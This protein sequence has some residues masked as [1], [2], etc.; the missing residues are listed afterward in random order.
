MGG[1]GRVHGCI[2]DINYYNHLFLNPFDGKLTPYYATS[3][4][5]KYVYPS[6]E[7]L[8]VE[9]CPSLESG[10]RKMVKSRDCNLPAVD[11]GMKEPAYYPETDIYGISRQM[12]KIQHLTGRNVIRQWNDAFLDLDDPEVPRMVVKALIGNG[13]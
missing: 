12:Y 6:V 4:R 9:K 3:M 10:F 13:K 2:V 5:D 1:D 7:M 11:T 8:V